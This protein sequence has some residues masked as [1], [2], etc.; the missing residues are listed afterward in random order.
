[1]LLVK[2]KS[3]N[4][5]TPPNHPAVTSEETG[6]STISGAGETGMSAVRGAG[7]TGQ[8]GATHS[9]KKDVC[10]RIA[11]VVVK[12]QGQHNTNVTNVLLDPGL[13]VTLC[14]VSLLKKLHVD[15]VLRNSH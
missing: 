13:D 6:M 14:A 3:N 9:G 15:G 4:N 8:C 7:D 1:M 11:P 5:S 10:L 12:G 2:T